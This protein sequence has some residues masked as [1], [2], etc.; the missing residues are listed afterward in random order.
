MARRRPEPSEVFD[1]GLQQ[2]RTA[3]AWERTAIAIM[4]A[5]T[6]LARYGSEDGHNFIAAVG[7]VEVIGGAVLLVW[8]GWH[9]ADL[10][11]TLRSGH[12]IV[13]RRAARWVGRFVVVFTGI[14]LVLA[15]LVSVVDR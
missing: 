9:Y 14:A 13:H 3:L 10:H 5:G 6:L 15:F 1:G 12:Q 4:V 2:E 7:M 11:D 8:A